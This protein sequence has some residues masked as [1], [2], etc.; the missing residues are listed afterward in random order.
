LGDL[1]SRAAIGLM[2]G[3]GRDR[4]YMY[5][6]IIIGAGSA[7]CVLAYRLSEDPRHKVLLIEAGTADE[8]PFITM[9]KGFG[10]LLL[11]PKMCW[12]F[13]VE[14]RAGSN[15]PEVWARGRALGGS[16]AV[17]GELYVRGQAPD[18]DDWVEMGAEGWGWRDLLPCFKAMENHALGGSEDRGGR[19]L[20]GVSIPPDSRHPAVSAFLDAA[21]AMGVPIKD[22][23]NAPG[24]EGAGRFPQSIRHGRRSSSASA[25]LKPAR[26]RPNLHLIKGAT[27]KRLLT[28]GRT[29]TGVLVARDGGAEEAFRGRETILCAGAVQSPKLLQLSGIGPAE[30]LRAIGVEAIHNSPGVGAN[31]IEHR[32]LRFQYRLDA[33]RLSYNREVSGWRLPINVLRYYAT[34]GGVLA[35]GAFDAGIAARSVPGL[36]RPDIQINMTPVTLAD[37]RTMTV[38]REPGLQ[39][40]GY[41]MRPTSQGSVTAVSADYRQPPRIIAN[42]LS[43]DEDRKTVLRM[44]D[45]IRRLAEQPALRALGMHETAPGDSVRSADDVIAHYLSEG[46]PCQHAT[47]TCRMGVDAR[48]VVAPDLRVHGVG[49]LRV[50]DGSIMPAMVSANP[51]APIMAMAWRGADIMLAEGR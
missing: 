10:K 18:F 9:P 8:H 5:D 31:L 19:G 25:F 22:D 12:Y 11:S 26:R 34:R 16:S 51:N 38:E 2:M 49:G 3:E 46:S 35:S 48:A 36:A 6:Y 24:E 30:A 15:S 50:L 41:P 29:V 45:Y 23:L 44:T 13:P 37:R 32:Y 1:V 28:E 14:G 17:N 33:D 39:I 42:Y 20:L 43:T 27:A 7:G 47:S 4:A 21:A 40:I